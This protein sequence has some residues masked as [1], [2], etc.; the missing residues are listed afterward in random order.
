VHTWLPGDLY[1][2]PAILSIP[3]NLG[4]RA[5]AVLLLQG[6]GARDADGAIGRSAPNRDLAWGLAS[7][8]MVVMR[9]AKRSFAYQKSI[10]TKRITVEQDI[11]EDAHRALNELRRQLMVDRSQVYIVGWGLGGRLA[12]RIAASAAGHGAPVAGVIALDSPSQPMDESM[13]AQTQ[14][15]ER[16]VGVDPQK[17]KRTSTNIRNFMKQLRAG[18]ASREAVIMG[19]GVPYWEGLLESD[20]EKSLEKADFPVLAVMPQRSF[21]TGETDIERWRTLLEAHAEEHPRSKVMPM[22]ELG[23]FLMYGKGKEMPYMFS[24]GDSPSAEAIA[25]ISEWIQKGDA[26]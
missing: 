23:H 16:A 18:R 20:L 17:L 14:Y 21:L 5:P 13:L 1:D 26:E 11:V 3:Q 12:P 6:R 7:Q 10:D 8:G 24:M 19:I 9:F 4:A 15:L 22:P 2:I 25:K